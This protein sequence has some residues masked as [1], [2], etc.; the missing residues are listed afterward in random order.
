MADPP[1]AFGQGQWFR[2]PSLFHQS[3]VAL[4]VLTFHASRKGRTSAIEEALLPSGYVAGEV[5]LFRD[6]PEAQVSA[7]WIGRVGHSHVP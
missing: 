7:A 3:T 5:G 4:V 1:G 2:C 6:A